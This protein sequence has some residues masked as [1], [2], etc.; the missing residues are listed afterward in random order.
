MGL[1]GVLF[2]VLGS[3]VLNLHECAKGIF[4]PFKTLLKEPGPRYMLCVAFIWSITANIDRIGIEASSPIIW[5]MS[6]YIVL[7]VL[8]FI[9]LIPRAGTAIS[10]VRTHWK[11]LLP[12]GAAVAAMLICHMTAISRGLVIYAVSVKR[13]SVLLSVIW[14]AIVFKEK[15]ISE[16]LLGASIMV[17]GVLLIS[18]N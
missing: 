6:A 9:P 1:V 4:A 3:Y 5:A 10:E 18:L 12:I 15:G 2:I 13:T 16:R 7:A 8:L 17:V 14:G 11:I